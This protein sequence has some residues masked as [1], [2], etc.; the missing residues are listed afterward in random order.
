MLVV[1]A[2]A[3]L[4]DRDIGKHRAVT[5]DIGGMEELGLAAG[6]HALEMLGLHAAE[7]VRLRDRIIG[8]EEETKRHASLLHGGRGLAQEQRRQGP[9]GDVIVPPFLVEF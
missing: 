1:A 9:G 3:S 4:L 7:Q 5:S 6:A 2:L 8:A